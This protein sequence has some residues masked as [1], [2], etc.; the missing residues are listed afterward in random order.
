MQLGIEWLNPM[1]TGT[2]ALFSIG[3]AQLYTYQQ[4]MKML[5]SAC[6]CSVIA[7]FISVKKNLSVL[8]IAVSL[9]SK[10]VA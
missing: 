8:V 4:Y 7:V 5:V 9:M 1:V 2:T 10:D 6:P 3:A